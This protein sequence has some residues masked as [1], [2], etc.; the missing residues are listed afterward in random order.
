MTATMTGRVVDAPLER[1]YEELRRL[2]RKAGDVSYGYIAR[3][4]T[5]GLSKTTVAAIFTG[6]GRVGPPRWENIACVFDVLHAKLDSTGVE[7]D[8]LGTKQALYQLHQQAV[9][10]PESEALAGAP[11]A[12]ST[13]LPSAAAVS[14]P[15]PAPAMELDTLLEPDGI[16]DGA[17]PWPAA[18]DLPAAPASSP[19]RNEAGGGGL[20]V[21]VLPDLAPDGPQASCPEVR[22]MEEDAQPVEK[23]ATFA[24]WGG[25]LRGQATVDRMRNWFGPCGLQLL[26]D[27]DNGHALAAFRLGVLLINRDAPQEGCLFLQRAVDGNT[28][29]RLTLPDLVVRDRL[30]GAI[31]TDICRHVADAYL[32]SGMPVMA[33][34]WNTYIDT[35][36]TRFPLA[37]LL[38]RRTQPFGRHARD[39]SHDLVHLETSEM[40]QISTIYW[41]KRAVGAPPKTALAGAVV[42]APC[43]SAA[44]AQASHWKP[45]WGHVFGDH[46]DAF[47]KEITTRG[48]KT[49]PPARRRRADAELR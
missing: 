31:V 49:E 40:N 26:R 6:Q 30:C 35:I 28:K 44:P 36:N 1:L 17:K 43:P 9:D 16:A 15:A 14:I 4:N 34:R 11:Q 41:P 8:G 10:A 2:R 13:G 32:T 7:T 39:V 48:V 38:Y 12:A 45:L 29:L 24:V 25:P 3:K 22:H 37:A 21:P 20:S 33:E 23:E 42:A 5:R 46:E 18:E 27:A 47:W 19:A